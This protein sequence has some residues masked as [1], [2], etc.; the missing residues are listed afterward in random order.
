MGCRVKGL[1][2][3][4]QGSGLP[5]KESAC[6]V[7][8]VCKV[9]RV[10]R[11]SKASGVCMGIGWGVYVAFILSVITRAWILGLWFRDNGVRF[12]GLIGFK[13]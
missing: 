4:V 13:V 8:R 11:I 7:G 10:C 9:C 12:R 2:L 6:G 3:P 1:G 5:F